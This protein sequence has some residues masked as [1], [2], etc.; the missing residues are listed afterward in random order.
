M[1]IVHMQSKTFHFKQNIAK[2]I[3]VALQSCKFI[4]A[5]AVELELLGIEVD[6][7]V[8]VST[9]VFADLVKSSKKKKKIERTP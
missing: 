8:V 2:L 9:T 3:K 6:S 4:G 5:E 1:F 7:E